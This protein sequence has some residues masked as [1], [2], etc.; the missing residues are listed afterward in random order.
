MK[1][2][3]KKYGCLSFAL[4]V[5]A[6]ISILASIKLVF[7]E[8]LVYVD[9]YGES[10]TYANLLRISL[11]FVVIAGLFEYYRKKKK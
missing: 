3:F 9:E 4:F 1:D 6:C 7:G 8:D 2:F 11:G 5:F 10:S